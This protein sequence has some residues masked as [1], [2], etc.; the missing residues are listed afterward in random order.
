MST[1]DAAVSPLPLPQ[2]EKAPM[3]KP[4][5]VQSCVM[6]QQRKVKCNR[7]FPCSNCIK[8]GNECIKSVPAPPRRKKRKVPQSELTAKIKHYERLLKGHGVTIHGGE[9]GMDMK[10]TDTNDTDTN[11]DDENG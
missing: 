9:Y 4:G 3:T 8:S 5:R 11:G 1:S 2:D 10:G 6:C 7:E